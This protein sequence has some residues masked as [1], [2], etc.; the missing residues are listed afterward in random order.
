[1]YKVQIM[2]N[3]RNKKYRALISFFALISDKFELTIYQQMLDTYGEHTQTIMN[4]LEKYLINTKLTNENAGN[5]IF[6]YK[7][8]K[9]YRYRVNSESI[10]CIKKEANAL[11]DWGGEEDLPEDLTFYKNNKPILIVV[12][13][14]DEAFV[15]LNEEKN[16][17]KFKQL[18]GLNLGP[19]K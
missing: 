8:M 5:H 7:P 18:E 16:I 11:F 14:E 9:L 13:H 12:G 10:R 3:P 15:E 6:K 1:M 19:E 4:F 17:K 2:N